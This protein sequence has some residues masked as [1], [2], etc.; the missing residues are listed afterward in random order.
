MPMVRRDAPRRPPGTLQ[1]GETVEVDKPKPQRNEEKRVTSLP[2]QQPVAIDAKS[3]TRKV[4]KE[5]IPTKQFDFS[6]TVGDGFRQKPKNSGSPVESSSLNNTGELK[7]PLGRVIKDEALRGAAYRIKKTGMENGR[8]DKKKKDDAEKTQDELAVTATRIK[9]QDLGQQQGPKSI[10]IHIGNV[11]TYNIYLNSDEKEK[12]LNG[13]SLPITFEG[14]DGLFG[15]S[16][17]SFASKKAQRG[18]QSNN[19]KPQYPRYTAKLAAT[20][21][22]ISTSMPSVDNKNSNTFKIAKVKRNNLITKDSSNSKDSREDP[23]TTGGSP[24]AHPHSV[25]I[26]SGYPTVI[27]AS[28]LT[29][30]KMY[31]PPPQRKEG[32]RRTLPSTSSTTPT[33]QDSG[34]Q[35][36]PIEIRPPK[37]RLGK[38]IL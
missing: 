1:R 5:N 22:P 28:V 21:I 36:S 18:Q 8:K 34:R 13:R 2:R 26:S 29:K 33:P 16:D 10:D 4:E 24:P 14:S 30:Y 12:L 38:P 19:P 15:G 27:P 9:K 32:P 25:G 7:K 6:R 23:V 3:L 37:P 11:N 20:T 17:P 31:Q 35:H